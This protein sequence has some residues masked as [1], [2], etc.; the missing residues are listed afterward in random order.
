M[1][2]VWPFSGGLWGVSG[3][4]E[5]RRARGHVPDVLKTSHV[6]PL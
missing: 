3:D 2:T 1:H 6:S 4:P 5:E